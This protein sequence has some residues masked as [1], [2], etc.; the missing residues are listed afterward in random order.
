MIG[1][2]GLAR[3]TSRAEFQ[4]THLRHCDIGKDERTGFRGAQE[5]KSAG[6]L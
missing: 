4:A 5:L 3:L 6:L 1:I 2:S